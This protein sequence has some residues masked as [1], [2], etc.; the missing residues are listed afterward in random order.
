MLSR[1]AIIV[2]VA[3]IALSACCLALRSRAAIRRAE[4]DTRSRIGHLA[5][6][7]DRAATI[8]GNKFSSIIGSGLVADA[9]SIPT[10]IWPQP[11]VEA[12]D[13]LF[14]DAWGQALHVRLSQKESNFVTGTIRYDLRIWSSGRNRVDELGKGDD[15]SISVAGVEC[16]TR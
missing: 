12:I 15:I 2:A 16:E 11:G 6:E 8:G 3:A 7:I 9:T 1:L 10:G 4:V 14:R 13:Y 5:K